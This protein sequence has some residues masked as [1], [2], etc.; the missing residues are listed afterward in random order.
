MEEMVRGK[1]RMGQR[2]G[3]R[4]CERERRNGREAVRGRGEWKRR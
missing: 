2:K 1:E 3:G 4:E